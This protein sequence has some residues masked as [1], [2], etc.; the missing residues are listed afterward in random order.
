MRWTLTEIAAAT[1]GRLRGDGST[2]VEG[3]T[4]DSRDVQPG[5]LFVPLVAERDGH[6]FIA[7][8]VAAGASAYLSAR[9]PSVSGAAA[10]RVDDTLGALTALA[11]EAR[12]RLGAVPVVGITGSVGKTTTKDLLAAVLGRDRRVWASARSFNNE[13]GVPITL[14][15]APD[16]TEAL[17]VEM[18]SRGP[19]H[20]AELCRIAR[21]IMGVVTAVGLSHTSELGS[22]AAVVSA[23]QELVESLPA[24]AAGGVAFLNAGV[25]EVAA[26]AE[27]TEARVVTFGD[28]GQVSARSLELDDKLTP[29]F[30]LHSP[31]GEID[32]ELGARGVHSVDNALAA[33]AVG[34]EL[35]VSLEDV[36]AGLAT[37]TLSPLR[38]EVLRTAEGARLLNDSYN[39]NPLSMRAALHALAALPAKRR[40]AVLGAMA[41]LGEF[42]A[43]EHAAIGSLA[44]QL[45]VEVIA[46]DTPD[47]ASGGAVI[48]A[49]GI[50][51]ALETLRDLGG[52]GAGDAVLVKGSRVAGLEHLAARLVAGSDA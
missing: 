8:A 27:A 46:V 47:Y 41:E 9:E 25:P 26:M 42:E 50:D 7:D 15:A 11:R 29:R 14:L 12:R 37:P 49:E 6:D 48:E 20:I 43:A 19:G 1:G 52:L 44:G 30:V 32:V 35:G 34:L 40:I 13:I 28:G 17:V 21:P 10:V 23:K 45:G 16:G 5:M 31:Q 3:V 24:G 4:Q 39:A 18:G 51:G 22:L 38:M 36:A 2:E 33:A